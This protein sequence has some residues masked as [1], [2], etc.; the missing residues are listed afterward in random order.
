MPL[1]LLTGAAWAAWN[2]SQGQYYV[3]VDDD[4]VA[5]FQGLSQGV[6]GLSL[7]HVYEA[8]DL[9]LDELPPFSRE[10]VERSIPAAG[11]DDAR[12]IVGRLQREAERCAALQQPTP[13]A[14]ASPS[15]AAGPSGAASTSPAPAA[16]PSGAPS[17][18]TP[19]PTPTLTQPVG[20][21][22]GAP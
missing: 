4:R 22:D 17:L 21:G 3:G 16:N 15:A 10:R 1:A 8:Q 9:T 19:T 12:Q 11:L 6:G 5:I 14:A 2:W 13:S 7:S 20:C 18:T